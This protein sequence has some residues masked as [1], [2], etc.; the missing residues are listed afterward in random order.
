MPKT[1]D[2]FAF[3]DVITK[4]CAYETRLKQIHEK[5]GFGSETDIDSKEFQEQKKK[6]RASKDFEE[7]EKLSNSADES[8]FGVVEKG[9]DELYINSGVDRIGALEQSIREFNHMLKRAN[10]L[11]ARVENH[12]RRLVKYRTRCNPISKNFDRAARLENHYL[13][14]LSNL[15]GV[16]TYAKDALYWQGKT[17]KRAFNEELG[18]RLRLCRR[19]KNFSQ[20]DVAKLLGVTKAA[21]AHYENGRRELPILFVYRFANIFNVSADYLLGRQK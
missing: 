21:Y 12:C 16:K 5:F 18:I 3:R 9:F 1:K 13:L 11:I 6:F 15:K 17:V 7:I 4:I 14:L 8:F 20:D 10:F 19:R 2:A